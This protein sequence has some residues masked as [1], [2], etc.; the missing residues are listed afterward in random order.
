M[1]LWSSQNDSIS[2]IITWSRIICLEFCTELEY[3]GITRINSVQSSSSP[4]T[5]PFTLWWDNQLMQ[6]VRQGDRCAV[7]RQVCCCQTGVL[8]SSATT[9]F[10]NSPTINYLTYLLTYTHI[11]SLTCHCYCCWCCYYYYYYHYFLSSVY[12][13]FFPKVSPYWTGALNWLLLFVLLNCKTVCSLHLTDSMCIIG[14]CHHMSS[15][16]SSDTTEQSSN[17]KQHKLLVK[18]HDT[19][20]SVTHNCH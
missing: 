7:I 16:I 9:M 19:Q 11:N 4:H 5:A 12:R 8:S 17:V 1:P 14:R 15:D 20:H 6:P 2:A 18:K 10:S 13:V 3:T